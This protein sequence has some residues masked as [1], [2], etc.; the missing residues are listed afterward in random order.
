M[1]KCPIASVGPKQIRMLRDRRADQ[2]GAAN[3]RKKYLSSMFGW[4]VDRDLMKTNPCRDVKRVRYATTGFHTWTVD[5]V[6]KYRERHLPG[7][8]AWLALGLLLFL[9]PR[10]QDVVW[11]GKQHLRDGGKSITFAPKKTMYLRTDAT[12]KPV[13]PI[14][15]EIIA[16][17]PT[18]RLTFLETAHGVPFTAAGFGN[19]FRDRCDEAGLPQCSAHGLR[20]AGATIAAENGATTPQLMALYDWSTEKRALVYIKAANQKKMSGKAGALIS[21]SDQTGNENCPTSVSHQKSV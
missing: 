9:G 5:E 2:P 12:S 11:L 17:S 18:G 1:A 10:R 15:A 19:W 6:I 3:N 16:M 7:T 14:L 13:L 4:T 20:K 21:S 8:K